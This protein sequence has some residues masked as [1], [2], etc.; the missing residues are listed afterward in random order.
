MG[1]CLSDCV[2]ILLNDRS[3]RVVLGRL[4]AVLRNSYNITSLGEDVLTVRI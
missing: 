4:G 1:V 2:I 3:R